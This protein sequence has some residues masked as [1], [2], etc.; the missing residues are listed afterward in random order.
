M[1]F[2]F[3]VLSL[4]TVV[5]FQNQGCIAASGDNGT[6]LTPT[7]CQQRGGSGNGVCANGF[8]I[9]CICKF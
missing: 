9:C 2:S 6:C 4:F 5:R 7:Q 3:S 1:K 8:G